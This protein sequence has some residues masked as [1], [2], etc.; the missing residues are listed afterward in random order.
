MG[1]YFINSPYFV[2]KYQ[3]AF[4]S[5]LSKK[6]AGERDFN[7][8][9]ILFAINDTLDT[10]EIFTDSK[11]IRI[12]SALASETEG[13]ALS[14]YGE[15][16]LSWMDSLNGETDYTLNPSIVLCILIVQSTSKCMMKMKHW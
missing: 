13:I 11:G 4:I 3:N 8:M 2:S 7:L 12:L 1:V 16:Y 9:E 6:F 10:A 5:G 14:H 15:L